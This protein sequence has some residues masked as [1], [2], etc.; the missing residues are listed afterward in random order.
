MN[1]QVLWYG[2]EITHQRNSAPS[3]WEEMPNFQA[4]RAARERHVRLPVPALEH[5][6]RLIAAVG[7]SK[8]EYAKVG[9]TYQQR[10]G[11]R[12]P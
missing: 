10:V 5:H 2:V 11:R 9:S 6:L 7:G 4:S 3:A 1:V 12:L 8:T